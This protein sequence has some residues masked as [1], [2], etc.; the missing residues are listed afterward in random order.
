MHLH[1]CACTACVS[2][3]SDFSSDGTAAEEDFALQDSV[4][5]WSQ[6]NGKGSE[7]TI[8]Y[9]YTNLFDGG[10]TG[11]ITNKEMKSAI[12]EAFRLWAQYAPIK[13]VEVED[14]GTK[15]RSNPD[16]A[17]IRIGHENLGGP[18]G[19]LG[20]ASLQ[21]F[22]D[23]A[24]EVAFDNRDQWE[25]DIEGAKSDFL[26][27]A[28]H[29]IGH[30]L[31]LRHSNQ[32][33]IMRPSL[34]DVY[35]GLGSA[36]LYSDDINGIQALYG[37]G[38]GSVQPLGESN[39]TP[40]PTLDPSPNP[41]PTPD[42]TPT[43]NPT[44]TPTPDPTPTPSPNEPVFS[45]QRSFAGT[46]GD[47]ILRGGSANQRIEGRNGNDRIS[48]GGGNDRVLGG[49]G[50]DRIAG[51]SGRD[52]LLGGRGNDN[53]NGGLGDDRLLGS[54]GRD[55]LIG[56]NASSG[57][58]RGERDVLIGGSQADT[59]V[60]GNRQSVFYDDGRAN[61]LGTADY[62]MIQD[63]KVA[64]GDRIQL[65]GEAGDYRLGSGSSNRG[66]V[67]GI[68]LE[69][70]GQYELIGVVRSDRTLSLDSAAFRFV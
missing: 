22:G 62:A 44:P 47:D 31:G 69:E 32:S 33:S 1:S 11:G 68:F 16:A 38:Q 53:L 58:G 54:S 19:T 7:I 49:N 41:T 17:D 18:G 43:P 65:K 37:S 30:A 25:T 59:F 63:F 6:P 12:E 21:Y 29:E 70:S 5:R 57:A 23:L 60:L 66:S 55:V 14:S 27:V 64:E 3:S 4:F 40:M 2:K 39:P 45:N 48:A 56:V 67:Q 46:N 51:Q 24:T 20:R 15:S 10:I 36:F 50:N 61:S 9:S 13:F 28:V 34:S 35:S 8:T 42:L 52:T 26:A